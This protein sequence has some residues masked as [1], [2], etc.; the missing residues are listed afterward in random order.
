MLS[1]PKSWLTKE[2]GVAEGNL[3]G[4]N[5]REARVKGRLDKGV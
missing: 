3:G 1:I 5:G 2:N 4:M